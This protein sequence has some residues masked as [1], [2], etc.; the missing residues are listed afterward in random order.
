MVKPVCAR[1]GS[2]SAEHTLNRY[3][4]APTSFDRSMPKTSQ[5]TA[6]SNGDNP[7]NSTTATVWRRLFL[8]ASFCTVSILP[9]PRRLR[10]GHTRAMFTVYCSGH[11][12]RVLLFPEHIVELQNEPDG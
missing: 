2:A 6:N 9:L 1:T 5:A 7:W 3:Q 4:G 11:A 10:Q 8:A 12:S